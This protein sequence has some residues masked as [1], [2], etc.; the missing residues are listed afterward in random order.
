MKKNRVLLLLLVLSVL[1]NGFFLIG[2]HRTRRALQSLKTTEGR[3]E[4]LAKRL[5]LTEEQ[6]NTCERI[7]AEHLQRIAEVR[8][9]KANEFD[10]LWRAI[11]QD[12]PDPA[13]LDRAVET[14]GGAMNERATITVK[15]LVELTRCMTPA[16]R[17]AFL[18]TIRR[19]KQL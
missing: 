17:K 8:R 14:L 15:Y 12:D 16:Q 18:K 2:A 6:K 9:S 7:Q 13:E 4:L 5:R 1:F 10:A 19:R 11:A 3:V